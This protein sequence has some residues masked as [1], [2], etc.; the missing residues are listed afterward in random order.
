M[1]SEDLSIVNVITNPDND[2]NL[3]I[4]YRAGYIVEWDIEKRRIRTLYERTLSVNCFVCF[5]IRICI[6]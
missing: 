5:N 1:S 6:R 2:N 4:G 3:L